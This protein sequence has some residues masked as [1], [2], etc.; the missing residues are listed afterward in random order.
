MSHNHDDDP[1]VA[2]KHRKYHAVDRALMFILT[3]EEYKHSIYWM[4]LAHI[5]LFATTFGTTLQKL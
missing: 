4:Y 5:V 1:S 3:S 2:L